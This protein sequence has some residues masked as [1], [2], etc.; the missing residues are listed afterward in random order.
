MKSNEHERFKRAQL[1]APVIKKKIIPTQPILY[2]NNTMSVSKMLFR[3]ISALK[4]DPKPLTNQDIIRKEM[5]DI[6]NTPELLEA[7]KKNE[8]ISY[9]ERDGTFQYQATYQ[10]RDK[11]LLSDNIRKIYTIF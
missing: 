11:V 1:N 5:V 4:D 10:I 7:V 2:E 8:R 6:L 3:V 9:N